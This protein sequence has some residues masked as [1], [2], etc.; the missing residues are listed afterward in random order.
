MAIRYLGAEMGAWYAK[1]NPP[2]ED[3]IVAS[4]TPEHWL[5]CDYGKVM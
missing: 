5:T 3:S 1:N 4:L 2:D